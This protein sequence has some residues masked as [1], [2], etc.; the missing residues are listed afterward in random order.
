MLNL[1]MNYFQNNQEKKNAL[2]DK[3]LNYYLMKLKCVFFFIKIK[4]VKKCDSKEF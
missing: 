3:L 1:C 2:K 4:I